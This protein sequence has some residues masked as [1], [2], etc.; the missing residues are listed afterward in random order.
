MSL[1]QSLHNAPVAAVPYVAPSPVKIEAYIEYYAQGDH[2]CSGA[3]NPQESGAVHSGVCTPTYWSKYQDWLITC[4]SNSPDSPYTAVL[5]NDPTGQGTCEGS[6]AVQTFSGTGASPATCVYVPY[7]YRSV[8]I[9]CG[10]SPAV[11][12]SAYYE[13]KFVNWMTQHKISATVS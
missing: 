10:G 8:R 2:S 3:Y 6:P 1:Y 7:L 12:G 4:E 13:E 9:N 11:K 5:Y